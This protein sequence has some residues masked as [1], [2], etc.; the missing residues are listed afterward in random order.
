MLLVTLLFGCSYI[1]EEMKAETPV[2]RNCETRVA[3]WQDA[4][5]DGVGTED[6]LYLGCAAEDGWVETAGDCDDGDASVTTGCDTGDTGADT[7]DTGTDTG[8]TSDTG[9]DT[10]DTS[11]TGDTATD[12]G[13]TS[14]TADTATGT[15]DTSDTATAPAD[16]SADSGSP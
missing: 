4:D 7:G 2:E 1:L 14:D 10:S 11:D 6:V 8:D 16:T 12:T 3:L 5:G 15:G 13:D 9:A